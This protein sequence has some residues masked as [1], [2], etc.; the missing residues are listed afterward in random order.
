MLLIKES[1]LIRL[2]RK[3][4]RYYIGR[5]RGIDIDINIS[6]SI[7]TEEVATFIGN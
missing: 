4:G 7:S 2:I 3:P 6:L 5:G 1:S